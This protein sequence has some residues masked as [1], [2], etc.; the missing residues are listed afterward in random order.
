MQP[1]LNASHSSNF[2]D[3]ITSEWNTK[4]NLTDRYAQI[5]KSSPKINYFFFL[6]CSI[7]VDGS[8]EMRR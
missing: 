2:N 1:S 8:E 4:L 7:G 3:D 5:H 6:A